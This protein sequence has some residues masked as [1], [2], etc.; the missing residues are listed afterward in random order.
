MSDHGGGH[1]SGSASYYG[2][3]GHHGHGQAATPPAYPAPHG[4]TPDI[5]RDSSRPVGGPYSADWPYAG[6]GPRAGAYLLDLL[7]GWA[8]LFL[9]ALL[10]GMVSSVTGNGVVGGAVSVVLCGA[11]LTWL[12][13][14]RYVRA[15]RTGQSLGKRV[16]GIWLVGERTGQPIGAARAFGRDIA[17]LI[18]G[19]CY[20]GYLMPLWDSRRQTVADK[21]AHTVVVRMADQFQ[22]GW[23]TSYAPQTYR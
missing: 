7:T 6:W 15:G 5:F 18:D 17:H 3:G 14:N 4:A 16:F 21:I 10:G 20:I 2:H 23:P 22:P 19:I 8:A 12:I 1:H 9:G 11:A 13:Y